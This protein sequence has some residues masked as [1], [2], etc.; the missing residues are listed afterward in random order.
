MLA[1]ALGVWARCCYFSFKFFGSVAITHCALICSRS[2]ATNMNAHSSRSHLIISLS[3]RS[4]NKFSGATKSSK[5]CV[6]YNYLSASFFLLTVQVYCRSRWFG[7][8]LQKWRGRR[9]ES[10][11]AEHQQEL[12]RAARR[13]DR[14]CVEAEAHTVQVR[15]IL[16]RFT[17]VSMLL[18][19]N[20]VPP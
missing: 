1:A 8:H 20:V 5:M 2:G 18:P 14:A 4:R 6:D 17:D 16:Y 19:T 15:T 9:E 3:V 7:G 13:N 12:E 11:S 10:G